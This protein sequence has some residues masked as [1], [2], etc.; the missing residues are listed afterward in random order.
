MLIQEEEYYSMIVNENVW[1]LCD[2]KC[3]TNDCRLYGCVV[4]HLPQSSVEKTIDYSIPDLLP[5]K[6]EGLNQEASEAI[7]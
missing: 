5:A 4:K 1:D 7:V 2:P 6:Q 3:G